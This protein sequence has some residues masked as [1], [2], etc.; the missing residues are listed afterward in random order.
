MCGIAGFIDLWSRSEGRPPDERAAGRRSAGTR[1]GGEA[2]VPPGNPAVA[3]VAL[4]WSG[5]VEL[6]SVPPPA[7]GGPERGSPTWTRTKPDAPTSSVAV[8]TPTTAL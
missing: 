3:P 5:A 8:V 1:A 6:E 4:P 7:R 2:S